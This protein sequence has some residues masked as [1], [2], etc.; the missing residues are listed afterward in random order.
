MH[1]IALTMSQQWRRS[2]QVIIWGMHTW[3]SNWDW[4]KSG[5]WRWRKWGALVFF[6]RSAYRRGNLKACI[7]CEQAWG[8]SK[9]KLILTGY[10]NTRCRIPLAACANAS[11]CGKRLFTSYPVSKNFDQPFIICFLACNA[12]SRP[13]K[14]W[15]RETKCT[16]GWSNWILHRKL[17]YYA[18]CLTAPFLISL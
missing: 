5:H 8:W 6:L 11:I 17:K 12:D 3:K 1:Q 2:D 9:F 10:V 18:C 4:R 15:N 16:T 7:F 14:I 13:G